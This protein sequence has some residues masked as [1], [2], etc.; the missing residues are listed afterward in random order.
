MKK[1]AIEHIRSEALKWTRRV[2]FQRFSSGA[3]QAAQNQGILDDVCSHM[4]RPKTTS[5]T[6]EE[7]KSYVEL[8]GF[9]L[10]TTEYINSLQ[11]LQIVCPKHGEQTVTLK[12]LRK[13]TGCFRC[14]QEIKVLGR[15]HSLQTVKNVIEKAGYKLLSTEYKSNDLPLLMECEKHGQ[16]S[17]TY[18]TIKSGHGCKACGYERL[19]NKIR[20]SIEEIAEIVLRTPYTLISKEYLKYDQKLILN[21]KTH[22][23]FEISLHSL[24]MGEGCSPCGWKKGGEKNKSSHEDFC[25][26]IS[27]LGYEIIGQYEGSH[28]SIA[29]KC[30]KHG[31]FTPVAYSLSNGH[32]CPKCA[33]DG[34]SKPEKE[35]FEFIKTFYPEAIENDRKEI[36]PLEL[37]IFIP[38]M[39]LAIEYYGLYWH[40]EEYKDNNYHFDKMKLCNERCIRLITIFEDEWRDRNEQVKGYLKSLL[41]KNEIKYFARKTKLKKVP[42][43]IAKNFLNAYHIQGSANFEIAF[44]LYNNE[45]LL[46]VMTGGPHHRQGHGNTFVL[47]RL[48]FKENVSIAGG[49]SR[50][51]KAL[52][53]YAKAGDYNKLLSWSD[54]RF[55]EG[56]VYETLG[57]HLE[58]EHGPDYSYVKQGVR[59]SKQSCQKKH[60]IKKGAKGTMENTEKELALTLE[61]YRIWDCGKKAWSISLK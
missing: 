47:N 18:W 36:S 30:S 32:G 54:N 59:V 28:K 42:K 37:D 44:G 15:R 13:G 2:D 51:L 58:D 33:S 24:K 14:G 6:H 4:E 56:R 17:G 34:T 41:N 52:L 26:K 60:L 8:R 5:L 40:S 35:V 38:S 25:K 57:F 7:V 19:G 21:C 29:V 20:T 27:H 45:E 31:I 48:A 11:K 1:L 49:S 55:S 12:W 39:N 43:E 9:T 23:N 3:Y 46:A 50:L 53:A 61:L 22:D 10:L 16:F